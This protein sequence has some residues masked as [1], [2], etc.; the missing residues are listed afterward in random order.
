MKKITI[1]LFFVL[2]S[3]SLALSQDY[4]C[5]DFTWEGDSI[6]GRYHPKLSINVAVNVDGLPHDFTMQLDLGAVKTNLYG[7]SLQA[8]MEVYPSLQEKLDSS[9]TFLIQ[10]QKNPIFRDMSLKMGDLEFKHV[11]IGLFKEYG[12][13]ISTDS[14]KTNSVKHIG[15]LAPDIFQDKILVID[16]PNQRICLAEELPKE[17]TNLNFQDLVLEGGR[18]LIPFEI[19]D[20]NEMLMFDTGSSMF[21]LLTTKNKAV[22]VTDGEVVDSLSVNSWGAEIPVYG[23]KI[24]ADVKL[25]GKALPPTLVYYVDNPQFDAGFKQMGIWGI[26]GNAYFLNSTVIIDYRNQKIA[27]K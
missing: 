14:V 16:Y 11:D 24:R 18:I 6:S 25:G 17:Y 7:N 13:P 9:K 5:F 27:I 1:S 3:S 10:N 21:A 23:S 15:T 26:T 12:T 4:G 19:K 20:S 22:A 2:L 8:Y